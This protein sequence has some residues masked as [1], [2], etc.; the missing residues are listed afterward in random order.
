MAET[1]FSLKEEHV[2]LTG[3]CK[4]VRSKK[5]QSPPDFRG[6]FLG[7]GK[8]TALKSLMAAKDPNEKW[9]I[10]VNELGE[11][12]I[13]GAVLERHNGIPDGRNRVAAVCAV[14]PAHKWV[15][16]YKKCCAMP[17]PDRLMI[18]ASGWLAHAASVTDELEKPNR[19]TA[20][21]K[22][23]P[24]LPLLIRANSLIPITRNKLCIKTKSAF[25]MY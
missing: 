22:S 17:Q 13:D 9:V 4:N 1:G 25:V 10:I 14:L 24:S 20:C 15:R 11:I 21:W 5:D 18:E 2:V 12:G 23:A 6:N 16:P 7:T 3:I 8:T 19:S